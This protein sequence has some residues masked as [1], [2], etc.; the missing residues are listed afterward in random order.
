MDAAVPEA[1]RVFGRAPIEVYGSTETGGIAYDREGN[2]TLAGAGVGRAL[3]GVS[4]LQLPGDRI[5]VSGPAVFRASGHRPADRA[6]LEPDGRLVLLGRAGRMIK[7]GG[8]RLDL[9]DLESA[10]RRL[11]GVSDAFA[12]PHP[13]DPEQLAAVLAT[14][15]A[16][17]PLRALL[18]QH[19]APWKIP[20][21]LVAVPVF[22]LT[23]RGKPDASALRAL[24]QR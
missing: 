18:R 10:L 8:R 16:P 9:G 3:V 4:I 17:L 7:I 23:P 13:D 12:A 1:R 14:T 5:R 19:L 6:R 11:P 15:L 22:P 24:L 21:R 2:D 20:R